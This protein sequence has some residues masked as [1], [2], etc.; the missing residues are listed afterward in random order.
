MT[1]THSTTATLMTSRSGRFLHCVIG[2]VFLAG[3]TSVPLDYPREPST[4]LNNTSDTTLA[5]ESHHFRQRQPDTNGFYPLHEGLDA[6]GARLTLIE[7]AEKS[8][9]AQYFLI[10]PDSAGLV[11]SA[12]LLEA[13]DRGVRVRFLI[14]DIFTTVSDSK[15]IHLHEHPNV[16]VRIFNPIS[17]K[18]IKAF[19]YLGN[20]GLLNRRMHNKSFTADYQIAVVGG[21]NIAEE[22]FQL[23]TSGEFI[24]FDM[25]VMG[26]IIGD[27]S[28][29]FDEYWNHELAVPM[30]ALYDRS[31]SEKMAEVKQEVSAKME[32]QRDSVY[33]RAVHTNLVHD[34]R[35]QT[36]IPHIADAK[37]IVDSPQKLEEKPTDENKIVMTEL[38]KV[39]KDAEEEIIIFTPYYIPGERGMETINEITAK[40][41]RVVVLTNSLASNNHTSVHSA[42]SSYRKRLLDA[43]V[44]LWEARANAAEVVNADG[45]KELEHLTL[46]TK[47]AIVDR[48]K[49]F[50]G[51]LNLDPR[52]T[53]LDSEIGLI[54]DS[55]ELGTLL[56]ENAMDGI[57]NMAY[58]LKL[59][60]NRKIRWHATIDGQEVV[61]T[62]EPLTS[63]WRR[64]QAWF[65]KI[66]PEK[67]L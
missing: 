45:S 18:G 59:D 22:Y 6:F 42:Y 64:F 63:W 11:F 61:E 27:I 14:D 30:H 21:R 9:D 50:V 20:F 1:N 17:R 65:L 62:R 10:K 28:A 67:E 26:P 66:A 19:N 36:I 35:A 46:H 32:A 43:G 47:G 7:S 60:E 41:V 48:Q 39:F 58:R 16:E 13:A 52:S 5:A 33:A 24:D 2:A 3:C 56:A 31:D 25:L 44:E 8:I 57:P 4:A 12:K 38:R 15:L 53:D 34:L 55:L 54:I 23:D 37:I 40:G 29:S 51:S 49:V